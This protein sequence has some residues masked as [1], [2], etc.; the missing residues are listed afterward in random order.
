MKNDKGITL[1]SLIIYV[2][3]MLVVVT[4]IATLTSFFYKNVD[5]DSLSKKSTEQYTN[6][7]KLFAKEINQKNNKII[8]CKIKNETVQ[9]KEYKFS[10]I[11]FSNGNQYTYKQI[12][13]SIYKN[14]KKI[15]EE[16]KDCDFSYSYVDSIYKIK[17]NFLTDN[18]ELTDEDAIIY[19]L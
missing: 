15:C 12:N 2:I 14:T 16:I 9:G 8:V 3:S 18:L 17:V 7:S 4:T 13:N 1:T 11:I 5:I 6:F 19:D 10:Y